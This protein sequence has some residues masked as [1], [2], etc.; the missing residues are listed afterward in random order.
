MLRKSRGPLTGWIGYTLAWNRRQFAQL[1]NG[2]AFPYRYDRRHDLSLVLI[3]KI[4]PKL[5]L[6]TTWVYGTGN[7]VTLATGKYNSF[8]N[9]IRRPPG[10][11]IKQPR[12][13]HFFDGGRN[14][15]RMRSYHRLDLG[16]TYSWERQKEMRN[17]KQSLNF[18]LYN[19]YNR[20]NPY[21]YFFTEDATQLD[22]NGQPGSVLKQFSLFPV[23]PSVSYSFSF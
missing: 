23:V 3:W 16:L 22:D 20:H 11:P 2:A 19:A 21:F 15:V 7:A 14:N 1:N 13:I 10:Y 17:W 6:S 8:L 12:D 5:S 4:S 18:S 9:D